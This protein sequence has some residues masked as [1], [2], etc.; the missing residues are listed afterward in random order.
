LGGQVR[1]LNQQRENALHEI[2]ELKVQLKLLEEA[3]DAVKM[4]LS[5]ANDSIRNG[6]FIDYL[7]LT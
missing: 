5:E 2:D 4:E 7:M 3:R 6:K 1:D